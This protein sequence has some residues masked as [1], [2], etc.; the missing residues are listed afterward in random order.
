MLP[1]TYRKIWRYLLVY[2]N[3]VCSNLRLVFPTL[4]KN[5][6]PLTMMPQFLQVLGKKI[7][8]ATTAQDSP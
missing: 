6:S 4:A 3:P 8:F 5:D 1:Y 7:E 2:T